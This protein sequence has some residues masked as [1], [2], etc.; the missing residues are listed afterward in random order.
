MAKVPKIR[1]RT[2][3]LN[4][5]YHHFHQHV[6]PGLLSIHAVKTEDQIADIFKKT[7]Q[8]DHFQNSSQTNQGM[9]K[10]SSRNEGVWDFTHLCYVVTLHDTLQFILHYVSHNLC[11]ILHYVMHTYRTLMT[12]TAQLILYHNITYV[13]H[14]LR[15]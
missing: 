12:R 3:H 14:S 15:A 1:P 11:L 13:V 2:K 4:I 8:R 5:K 6:Q 7:S 9:V 10:A